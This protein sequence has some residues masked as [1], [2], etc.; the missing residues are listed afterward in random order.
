MLS[1]FGSS[2]RLLLRSTTTMPTTAS[3]VFRSSSVLFPLSRT[4]LATTA[5]TIN[6]ISSL[7]RFT[8]TPHRSAIEPPRLSPEET[9]RL[10][11]QAEKEAKIKRAKDHAQRILAKVPARF[12]PHAEKLLTEP[13]SFVFCF[14]ILHELS[15]VLP[16]FALFW[17]FQYLD[18]APPLP[19]NLIEKGTE[20][21]SKAVEPEKIPAGA[22]GAK[23]L[24]QGATAYI[25]VK[26]LLPV[27]IPLCLLATPW[28]VRRTIDPIKEVFRL[29]RA[30]KAH[31]QGPKLRRPS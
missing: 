20:F 22:A 18:W 25:L 24:A 13:G 21:F 11:Q 28:L 31:K 5:I 3:S 16:L 15:A 23:Y 14:L 17:L 27:R 9:I 26:F 19:D 30:I 2:G 10:Q 8:T 7:R 6:S 12:R 29:R 4:R 1:I